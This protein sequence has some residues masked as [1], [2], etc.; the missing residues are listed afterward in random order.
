M[1]AAVLCAALAFALASA[2]HAQDDALSRPGFLEAM[3]LLETRE[4]TIRH[5]EAPDFSISLPESED[6]EVRRAEAPP[7]APDFVAAWEFLGDEGPVETLTLTL[8]R[9]DTAEPEARRFAMANLL[10]LRSYPEIARRVP[11]ARLTGFGPLARDDDLTAVQAFGAFETEG[12]R[13]LIFRHVGL[14]EEGRRE[15]LVAIVNT[16]AARLPV[17]TEQDLY[18]TYAGHAIASIRLVP[19]AADAA[20]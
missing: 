12:G 20:E 6:V 11:N 2:G 17:R 1:R 16:D 14:M 15:T 8:A 9:V 10:V 4:E 13:S 19:E 5:P 7:D 3:G 18:D